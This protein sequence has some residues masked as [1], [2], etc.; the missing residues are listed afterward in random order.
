MYVK[1]KL[2]A[3]KL[4]IQM[5]FTVTHVAAVIVFLANL[6]TLHSSRVASYRIPC[7]K[8]PNS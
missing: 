5:L 2:Y 8:S 1:Y 4:S 6:P 3:V 7:N